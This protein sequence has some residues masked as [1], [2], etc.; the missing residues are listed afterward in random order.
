[1]QLVILGLLVGLFYVLF[2]NKEAKIISLNV[3]CREVVISEKT[4]VLQRSFTIEDRAQGLSGTLSLPENGGMI[5]E[6][7]TYGRH[8]FWMKD[9]LIPIDIIFVRDDIITDIYKSVTPETFPESFS[10][11]TDIN[12][13]IELNAGVSEKSNFEVGEKIKISAP[14]S[15]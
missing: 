5:F 3:N 15:C 9:M 7:G 12:I 11:H 2:W 10:P 8:G 13:V 1:M 14:E 6:F 4:F